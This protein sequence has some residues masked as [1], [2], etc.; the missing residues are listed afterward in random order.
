MRLRH[1][2]RDHRPAGEHFDQRLRRLARE[3]GTGRLRPPLPCLHPV[4]QQQRRQ[5]RLLGPS[6]EGRQPRLGRPLPAQ[7][8]T[9]RQAQRQ[10]RRPQRPVTRRQNRRLQIARRP[11]R[12]SHAPSVQQK[13]CP[14]QRM[15]RLRAHHDLGEA[16]DCLPGESEKRGQARRPAPC[17]GFR[18]A[19]QPAHGPGRLLEVPTLIAR[20]HPQGHEQSQPL[21]PEPRARPPAQFCH[22]L[23]SQPQP[24]P[25]AC[26][27]HPL[28]Q[29]SLDK[30]RPGQIAAQP[31]LRRQPVVRLEQ[32]VAFE[33]RQERYIVLQLGT[34][35]EPRLR[36]VDDVIE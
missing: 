36:R 34:G 16:F 28:G 25:L 18:P 3:I 27:R 7:G 14:R 35:K 2:G 30:D 11:L 17:P 26:P 19:G 13:G 1:R 32:A 20:P 4:E 29:P 31:S 9:A 8:R 24:G 12:A 5:P 15:Q 33:L 6:V 10:K 23:Q 22:V 21:H